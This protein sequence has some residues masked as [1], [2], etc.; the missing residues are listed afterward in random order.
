MTKRIWT[1]TC[2]VLMGVATAAALSAQTTAT[3]SPQSTASRADR[4]ITVTGC[5]KA[6]PGSA[7]SATDVT[8]PTGTTGTAGTTST[9][10]E[11]VAA[12]KFLLTDAAPSAADTSSAPATTTGAPAQTASPSAAQTYRLI[13]NSAALVPHVGRKLELT[14]TLVDNPDSAAVASSTPADA[15]MLALRVES[16]KVVAASCS[17]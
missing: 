6:A 8:T 3:S 17:Q 16:G 4:K 13:A 14:G 12:Q 9:T 1:E 11:A 15:R 10:A 7:P 2:A 5:L